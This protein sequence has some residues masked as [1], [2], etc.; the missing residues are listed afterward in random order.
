MKRIKLEEPMVEEP[1]Q[2]KRGRGNPNLKKGVSLNPAGK[3]KGAQNKITREMKEAMLRGMAMAGSNGKGK[4]GVE[5]YFFHL[6]WRKP[7]IFG[8]LLERL[9]PFALVGANGGAVQIEYSNREEVIQRMKERN[10]PVPKSLMSPATHDAPQ[11][12]Q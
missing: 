12:K 10:L 6:A 8:R 11:A 7:E 3:P 4:D 2:K 9:L 1:Q 5:G